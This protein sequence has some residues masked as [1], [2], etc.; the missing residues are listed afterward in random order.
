MRA[1]ITVYAVIR[2]MRHVLNKACGSNSI[3][4]QALVLFAF[5]ISAIPRNLTVKCPSVANIIL[6][7]A[8]IIPATTLLAD[9]GV[10]TEKYTG[11][12]ALIAGRSSEGDQ[13]YRIIRPGDTSVVKNMAGHEEKRV[14][15]GSSAS[16]H[17]DMHSGEITG[18]IEVVYDLY[19]QVSQLVVLLKNAKPGPCANRFEEHYELT[20][21]RY[22]TSKDGKYFW[23]RGSFKRT[24]TVSSISN[25]PHCPQFTIGKL[26]DAAAWGGFFNSGSEAYS[27]SDKT[28]LSGHYALIFDGTG[29]HVYYDE[30][31]S[32]REINGYFKGRLLAGLS[33]EQDTKDV[34]TLYKRILMGNFSEEDR[35]K[36][37]DFYPVKA[38]RQ[39]HDVFMHFMRA[40]IDVPEVLRDRLKE[41]DYV[42]LRENLG[43]GLNDKNHRLVRYFRHRDR[44]RDLAR[45]ETE[46]EIKHVAQ[47]IYA[48]TTTMIALVGGAPAGLALAAFNINL[49][50]FRSLQP[51]SE[52]DGH[53]LTAIRAIWA[54]I[55]TTNL[56]AVFDASYAFILDHINDRSAGSRWRDDLPHDFFALSR[57]EHSLREE[58]QR[59]LKD[60]VFQRAILMQM[61]RMYQET[62]AKYPDVNHWGAA[63]DPRAAEYMDPEKLKALREGYVLISPTH[64]TNS[65]ALAEQLRRK[66]QAELDML[67]ARDRYLAAWY[68]LGYHESQPPQWP[69]DHKT[70]A[71]GNR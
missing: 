55:P 25:N 70:H 1:I 12:A 5:R 40:G 33:M 2:W 43:K 34:L 64:N 42:K 44:N 67:L 41:N 57:L 39:V 66:T 48:A 19:T 8:L 49:A 18:T 32:P 51:G 60:A 36:A 47:V 27:V 20:G 45:R 17:V 68:Y 30:E 62:R 16:I 28:R 7:A 59:T 63:L 50:Y 10:G 46:R 52:A 71:K 4:G 65:S 22:R 11:W 61:F 14:V 56:A 13:L 15:H 29:G 3:L 9:E 35:R 23:A 58:F 54:A 21:K 24:T 31:Q 38:A 69:I 26:E 6:A 37:V 53:R